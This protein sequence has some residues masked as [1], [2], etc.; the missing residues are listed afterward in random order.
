MTGQELP[1]ANRERDQADAAHSCSSSVSAGRLTASNYSAHSFL[2][3]AFALVFF[4]QGH[5][6]REDRREG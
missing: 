6:A 2:F 1:N 3:F 4:N 5:A